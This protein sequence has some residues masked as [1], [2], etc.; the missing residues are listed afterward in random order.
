MLPRLEAEES[1]LTAVRVSVGA[2]GTQDG[3]KN[4]VRAWERLASSGQSQSARHRKRPTPEVLAAMGI[5]YKIAK[6]ATKGAAR[7]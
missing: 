2:R 3:T 1:M 4:I 5:G 7:G 6:P